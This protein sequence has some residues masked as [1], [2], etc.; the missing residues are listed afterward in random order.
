MYTNPEGYERYMGRWSARL[1]PR[2]ME[3]ADIAEDAFVLDV[4]S[5]T[6]VLGHALTGA[7]RRPR[8]VAVDPVADYVDYARRRPGAEGILSGVAGAEALPF[9]DNGFDAALALLILQE[10]AD[11]PRAL[12]EMRRVTRPGGR[13]AACQWDFRDGMPML[14]LFW[15][16]VAAVAPE[17]AR[18]KASRSVSEGFSDRAALANLWAGGGLV[19]VGTVGL[20]VAMEFASFEDYWSPFLDGAT[21]TGVFARDL[22]EKVRR[23]VARDLR[24]RILGHDARDRAFTLEARAWAVR[25]TVPKA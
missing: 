16:A 7:G 17:A 11:V 22:P 10:I 6:G 14:S 9:A 13:V 23:A 2:F 5:G 12:A 24:E 15:Q 4:G 8:V 19:A 18:E 25:G 1:A 21:P 3:F 20:V